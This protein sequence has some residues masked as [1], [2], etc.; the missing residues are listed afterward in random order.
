LEVSMSTRRINL[1]TPE[2]PDPACMEWMAA[3]GIDPWKVP[4]A[5]EVAVHDGQITFIEFVTGPDGFKKLGSD[6]Y[7]KAL[8]TVPLVSAPENHGL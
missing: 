1:N 2:I 3:N 5:Q 8:R 4:A 7:E 6:G